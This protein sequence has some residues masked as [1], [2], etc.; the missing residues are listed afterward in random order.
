MNIPI[1]I[2]YLL[3]KLLFVHLYFN[4]PVY[5]PY[6]NVFSVSF[7]QCDR[8]NADWVHLGNSC[9]NMCWNNQDATPN[10]TIPVI[11]QRNQ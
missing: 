3:V 8:Y 4:I 5:I 10:N 7:R 11:S 2:L 9:E 6:L 1:H